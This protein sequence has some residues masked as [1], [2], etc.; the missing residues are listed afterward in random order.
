MQKP[1]NCAT[2]F[3]SHKEKPQSVEQLGRPA[4]MVC[5]RNPPQVYAVAGQGGLGLGSA[6]PM[7]SPDSRCGEYDRNLLLE[8]PGF[9]DSH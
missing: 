8:L 6:F 2:C 5:R 4:P 7:V 9:S 1:K 3:H